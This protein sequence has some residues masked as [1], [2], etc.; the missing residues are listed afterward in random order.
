[1]KTPAVKGL[2]GAVAAVVLALSAQHATAADVELT[3]NRYSQWPKKSLGEA[4]SET[5]RLTGT[6]S[7]L[8]ADGTAEVEVL[9]AMT[10]HADDYDGWKT[11]PTVKAFSAG[12]HAQGETWSADV[13]GLSTGKWYACAFA[14]YDNQHFRAQRVVPLLRGSQ[15]YYPPMYHLKSSASWQP[16]RCYDGDTSTVGDDSKVNNAYFHMGEPFVDNEIVTIRYWF[17][18]TNYERAVNSKFYA[19]ESANLDFGD[20]SRD[21]AD[22]A[23]EVYSTTKDPSPSWTLISQISVRDYPDAE[24][25]IYYEL[26][27]S[28]LP[29]FAQYLRL[30]G[31]NWW[32]NWA[33]I[34]FRTVPR[35]P[36]P[37][38]TMSLGTVGG[39]YVGLEGFLNYRGY[40][41][42][43]CVI[44]VSC[45]KEGSEPDYQP[46][47]DL[48]WENQTALHA[49]VQG[50][51]GETDYVLNAIVSN[52][53]GGAGLA[54]LST[55][56]TTGVAVVEPPKV[57]SVTVTPNQDGTVTF[58]WN[59][60]HAGTGATKADVYVQWGPDAEN[61]GER[62]LLKEGATPGTST[63][64][65]SD[66]PPGE[67][68]VFAIVAVNAEGQENDPVV[69]PVVT[70]V[71]RSYFSSTTKITRLTDG[72]SLQV[73]GRIDPLGLGTTDVY[74]AYGAASGTSETWVRI[75]QFDVHSPEL[76]FN[77]TV[78]PTVSGSVSCRLVASN[79]TDSASWMTSVLASTNLM[80]LALAVSASTPYEKRTNLR[81]VCDGSL[82]T[83]CEIDSK[84][85]PL[86]LDL[87]SVKPIQGLRLATRPDGT[88]S[89]CLDSLVILSSCDGTAYEPFW[90]NDGTV[91]IANND[92]TDIVLEVPHSAR[93]LKLSCS[94]NYLPIAEVQPVGDGDT[95]SI[96][97]NPP[98]IWAGSAAG[99]LAKDDQEGIHVGGTIVS[100]G[101]AQVWAVAAPTDCGADLEAWRRAGVVRELG[102][103]ERGQAIT[104]VLP[105]APRGLVYVKLLAVAGN[106]SAV[107]PIPHIVPVGTKGVLLPLYVHVG[108]TTKT[109]YSMQEAY[110]GKFNTFPDYGTEKYGHIFRLDPEK[111]DVKSVRVWPR[112]DQK[113]RLITIVVDVTD[114]AAE[115]DATPLVTGERPVFSYE[116]SPQRVWR[117]AA[118]VYSR[119][120]AADDLSCKDIPVALGRKARYLRISGADYQN[121]SEIEIRAVRRGGCALIVR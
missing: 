104:G 73:S 11:D 44:Y 48:V 5:N 85:V 102:V 2:F 43:G 105:G 21:T 96:K 111:W 42:E 101:P 51:E 74:L 62:H 34:E 54:V 87:G 89:Q 10:N 107:S 9:V 31:S 92:F 110:D 106:E 23:R 30:N 76:L 116:I 60:V 22:T 53:V 49:T 7:A 71:G 108:S 70:T 80:G 57:E 52:V 36:M 15:C 56:F 90:S 100:G 58:S 79:Y 8:P 66:V 112:S 67:D 24:K 26:P 82:S 117:R 93:Y 95:L 78:V 91:R 120:D 4:D 109:G 121:I 118:R 32:F 37:M 47:P 46:L 39:T 72:C 75:A 65:R 63:V 114:D 25:S 113:G 18:T 103:F 83:F 29:R 81:D 12:T 99:L 45:V 88:W 1:M 35:G 19:T 28:N 86:M 20:V 84:G 40:G 68:L 17:R 98:R 119:M 59:L 69:T 115:F 33:E 55:N 61:L 64:D 16:Y 27:V 77:A 94:G 97:A 13:T 38:A 6:V 14:A 3:M 50:L 41:C